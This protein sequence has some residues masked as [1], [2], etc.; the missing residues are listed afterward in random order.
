MKAL[1]FAI[2]AGVAMLFASNALAKPPGHH[3]QRSHYGY[4]SN[5][6]RYYYHNRALDDCYSRFP[7]TRN[8]RSVRNPYDPYGPWIRWDT[9]RG[10]FYFSW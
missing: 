6:Y 5:Y 3:G 9:R 1:L 4:Q 10:S 7:Y 2:L 8:Y